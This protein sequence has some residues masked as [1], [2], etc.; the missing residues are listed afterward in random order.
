MLLYVFTFIAL[1]ALR[2]EAHYVIAAGLVAA[3]GWTA[4]AAYAV[5]ASGGYEMLTRDY[6]H[7]LTSNS[8]LI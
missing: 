2:F 8:I 5:I 1:R 6:V 3:I 7:Y 4:L